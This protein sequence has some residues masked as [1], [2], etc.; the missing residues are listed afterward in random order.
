[1]FVYSQLLLQ[2]TSYHRNL[3]FVRI[4]AILR[5]YFNLWTDMYF[6]LMMTLTIA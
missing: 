6:M 5:N 1:M 3:S 2:G 4:N